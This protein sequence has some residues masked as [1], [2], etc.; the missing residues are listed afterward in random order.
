MVAHDPLHGSG[1]VV[2]PHPAHASGDDAQAPQRIGM[3]DT[4]RRQPAVDEP[5]HSVPVHAIV[6]A[7]PRQRTVP[8]QPTCD[9]NRKSAGMFMGTP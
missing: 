8:D 3:I 5:P 9:R 4:Q 6:L 7:P 2:L 1:R